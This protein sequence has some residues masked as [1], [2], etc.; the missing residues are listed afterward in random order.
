M[1]RHL[2]LAGLVLLAASA[3]GR[4]A[5]QKVAQAFQAAASAPDEIPKVLNTD[6]PFRYP[7]ALYARKVQGNVTLRLR[8]DRDGAV[9]ADST[10]VE[11]P[12]G[13]PALDTAAITGARELRF[14]PAK[15]KG[16]PMPV[17]ILFPVYFRHPE[18]SALPGDTIL[19]R[20][21]GAPVTTGG[22]E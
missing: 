12:S 7:A 8:L 21:G 9:V 14:V 17:T 11:E 10:R 16:E 6:L 1:N 15:L 20:Q 22:G 13:Y 18:A 4:D 3:C 19:N 5:P 2:V